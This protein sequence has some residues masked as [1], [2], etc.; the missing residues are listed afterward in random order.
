MLFSHRLPHLT[1]AS[2]RLTK[3]D[4]G[5]RLAQHRTLL[6][7]KKDECRH[8]A[9]DKRL[10]L[11]LALLLLHGK[12]IRMLGAVLLDNGKVLLITL[13]VS[14]PALLVDI[15]GLL[16]QCLPSATLLAANV[17]KGHGGILLHDLRANLLA[18]KQVIRRRA[19][20]MQHDRSRR[21]R[22]NI[23]L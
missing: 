16:R 9:L 14:L 5:I 7:A 8:T 23:L 2:T 4:V 21:R 19:L 15:L 13:L 11:L 18:E 10:A 12:Q 6:L 20:G 3:L 22:R 17:T 1:Q